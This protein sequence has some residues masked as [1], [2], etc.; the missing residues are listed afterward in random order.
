MPDNVMVPDAVPP[1]R[2]VSVPPFIV[3]PLAVPPE[4]TFSTPP[5]LIVAPLAAGRSPRREPTELARS[6]AALGALDTAWAQLRAGLH[7]GSLSGNLSIT[8][9]QRARGM[10]LRAV[11][12]EAIAGDEGTIA[13]IEELTVE[14]LRVLEVPNSD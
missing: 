2:I 7:S 8:D 1:D 11:I 6:A 13:R 4:Y 12:E 5:L 9:E 3:V 10:E 14:Y